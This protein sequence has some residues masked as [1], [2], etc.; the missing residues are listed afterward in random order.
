APRVR[1]YSAIPPRRTGS[2]GCSTWTRRGGR[3]SSP[4][5]TSHRSSRKL[6]PS[7]SPRPRR[8][9]APTRREEAPLTTPIN[10]SAA[11]AHRHG[12]SPA[13]HYR[14]AT[15]YG[16]NIFYREAGPTDAPALLL[17][18]GFPSS[19][20]MFRNLI[21]QLADAYH[22]IAPDYPAFGHSDTPDRTQFTYSFDHIADVIDDLLDAL[23]VRR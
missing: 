11:D 10:R 15:I 23:G 22:V 2:G 21:P 9:S 5:P 3:G 6:E 18:H 4:T 20:R 7:A 17:L 1:R 14:T 8:C 16:L 13:P 12:S 19:S